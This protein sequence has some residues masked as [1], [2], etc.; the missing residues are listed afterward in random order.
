MKIKIWLSL[1]FSDSNSCQ[2]Q[3]WISEQ[4]DL[5]PSF[6][7]S[8][9]WTPEK[10]IWYAAEASGRVGGGWG[11][12]GSGAWSDPGIPVLPGDRFRLVS[13]GTPACPSVWE[14]ALISP[15]RNL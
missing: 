14:V 12:G 15:L 13:Y 4:R 6:V 8:K 9:N 7:R 10:G 1:E 2:L 11:G 3:S 5:I